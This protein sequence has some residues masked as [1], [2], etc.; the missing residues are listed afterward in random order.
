[1]DVTDCLEVEYT[2]GKTEPATSECNSIHRAKRLLATRSH[3]EVLS[4]AQ[5]GCHAEG[6]PWQEPSHIESCGLD[7]VVSSGGD[8]SG[9]SARIVIK[10]LTGEIICKSFIRRCGEPRS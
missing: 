5:A 6:W 1:M 3:D 9:R 2:E 7:W 4:I 10:K 8:E